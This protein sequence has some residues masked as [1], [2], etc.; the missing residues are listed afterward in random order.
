VDEAGAT[1]TKDCD[2]CHTI[3]AQGPSD[4]LGELEQSITGLEFVHPVDIGEQW[5]E[6]NCTGCHNAN[7]G[8]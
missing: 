5:R 4:D 6:I 7:E 3:L 1:I 8:Y 2:A